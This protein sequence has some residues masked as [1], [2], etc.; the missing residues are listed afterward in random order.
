MNTV[1]VPVPML[2]KIKVVLGSV[3][4]KEN[5]TEGVGLMHKKLYDELETILSTSKDSK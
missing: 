4:A 5:T 2:K 3:C 1:S